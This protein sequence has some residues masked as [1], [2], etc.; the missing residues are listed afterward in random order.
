MSWEMLES[1]SLAFLE[2]HRLPTFKLVTVVSAF[3]ISPSLQISL[4]TLKNGMNYER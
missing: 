1:S 2:I 3:S 4:L